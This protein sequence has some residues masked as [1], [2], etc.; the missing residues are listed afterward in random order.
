MSAAVP[1]PRLNAWRGGAGSPGSLAPVQPSNAPIAARRQSFL[2]NIPVF[3]DPR[4]ALRGLSDGAKIRALW[5][6]QPVSDAQNL[7][8]R[9]MTMATER[10]IAANRENAKRS[11]GPK[12]NKG[13]R[14]SSRNALRHGLSCTAPSEECGSVDIGYLTA[15]LID[16]GANEVQ[17]L[18]ARQV[19]QAHL[20]VLRVR[21]IRAA[22]LA[23]LNSHGG[24][25][26]NLRQLLALDRYERIARTKR[27]IAAK[28]FH[29]E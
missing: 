4:S 28:G 19:A 26:G 2:S 17:I 9:R 18:A 24:H 14:A 27:R 7:L 5:L 1:W 15:A 6:K 20:D 22:W 23:S 10:Q 29:S 21:T 13:R 11:S 8:T 25:R 3:F 16:E 12:T